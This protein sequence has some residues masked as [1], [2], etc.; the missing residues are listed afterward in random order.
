MITLF[1]H[2][3]FC[4]CVLS[5]VFVTYGLSPTRLLCPLN[6]SGKNTGVACHFLLQGI[7]LAQEL[8]S[9]LLCLLHL[10]ADSIA[11]SR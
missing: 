6:F 5:P 9:C 3:I 10:Q 11:L 1:D 4:V 8:N 2:C 7:L